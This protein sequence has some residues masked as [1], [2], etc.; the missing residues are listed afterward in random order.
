MQFMSSVLFV[1]VLLCGICSAELGYFWQISDT[2]MQSDYKQGSDPSQRCWTGTGDAGLFGHY[3]CR[4]PYA[5]EDTAMSLM[6]T[7]RPEE[8]PNS[9]PMFILWTGDSVA[10]RGG[11]YN[12]DVIKFDLKNVT[13]RLQMLQNDFKTKVPIYPVIG[14]HDAYPQHQLP[15]SD[16]W[17]YKIAAEYWKPFLP[18]SALETLGVHGYYALNINSDLRLIVINTVLYYGNNNMTVN[19]TDPGN[20]MKWL[21]AQ[22][23]EAKRAGQSVYI[24]GHVPIRGLGGFH[25]KFELPLLKKM[26]GYHDII[27]SSFWGHCHTDAFQLYGNCSDNFDC[28]V[29]HLAGSLNSDDNRNPSIRRYVVDK[30]KK[31]T[32]LDWR[33]YYMNLKKAN[34]EGKITWETLY[35]AK[36]SFNITDASARSIRS[37]ASRLR[38]EE[39]LAQRIWDHW[40]GGFDM[41][42][43]DDKCR[44]T[45][46]CVILHPSQDGYNK[47]M[48]S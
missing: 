48:N 17:V 35:T 6:P 11:I 20:Q 19:E 16:Y 2:H 25:K 12:E 31:Y 23:E 8:C 28:H 38:K 24:A 21:K 33:T 4:S 5:V 46:Y 27:K 40:H 32:I 29:A 18:Q 13:I 7:L 10:M 47:C 42:Q 37:L 22:L 43:C 30:S 26:E 14:N 36:T 44:K 45:I 3:K 41:G 34:E 1:V 15:G 39:A 9:D